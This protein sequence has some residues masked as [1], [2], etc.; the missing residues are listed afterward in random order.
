M[1]G[2]INDLDLTLRG[3]ESGLRV[4]EIAT[5]K[6]R[7]CRIEDPIDG[8]LSD[9]AL[10]DFDYIPVAQDGVIV[11]VIERAARGSGPEDGRRKPLSGAMLVSGSLPLA[12]FVPM[13][14]Q[15]PYWLVVQDSGATGIVTR[16]DLLKLP[17]RL[18]AFALIIHLETVLSALIHLLY[19]DG[20][21]RWLAELSAKRQ[22]ELQ[23]NYDGL[24][25]S[26]DNPD[27]LELTYF[28]DKVT[29]LVDKK[30][31][32]NRR[33]L[34]GSSLAWEPSDG[35]RAILWR[36]SEERNN[37]AHPKNYA[38]SDTALIGFLEVLAYTHHCID[39]LKRDVDRLPAQ[40]FRLHA[41]SAGGAHRGY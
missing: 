38:S 10:L 22:R 19:P 8:V 9:S 33:A 41:E 3:L 27:W 39:E 4:Q 2:H 37:V 11:G 12:A 36:I 16:S 32:H 29:I 15:R 30:A 1:S 26:R 21:A 13:M 25:K 24:A 28:S 17:V 20:H 18:Y 23:N 31:T 34:T 5:A 40:A 6:P 7:T 14:V 35:L